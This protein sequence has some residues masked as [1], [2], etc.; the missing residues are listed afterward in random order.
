MS[1]LIHIIILPII[2]FM[3]IFC[4]NTIAFVDIIFLFFYALYLLY[5]LIK[6]FI[7]RG[8]NGRITFEE[9]TEEEKQKKHKNRKNNAPEE[10]GQ[11]AD[12]DA[13]IAEEDGKIVDEEKGVMEEE[14]RVKKMPESTDQERQ[15]KKTANENLQDRKDKLKERKGDH[16]ERK[17]RH[18]ERKA[19]HNAQKKLT[20]E[21]ERINNMDKNKPRAKARAQNALNKLQ[22]DLETKKMNQQIHNA[23]IDE[24]KEKQTKINKMTDGPKKTAAQSK[25]DKKI[26]KY[27]KKSGKPS[28]KKKIKTRVSKSKL[29]K[30]VSKGSKAVTKVTTTVDNI[31]D[32]A[33]SKLNRGRTSIKTNLGNTKVGKGV[34]K[35]GKGAGK[36]KK[37]VAKPLKPISK[38]DTK[39]KAMPETSKRWSNKIVEK[40]YGS[41]GKPKPKIKFKLSSKGLKKIKGVK[42]L[43]KGLA[44]AGKVMGKAGIVGAIITSGIEMRSDW[45]D[46]DKDTITKVGDVA[47]DAAKGAA[48]LYGGEVGAM[49]GEAV[50]N[51]LGASL[52]CLIPP[53]LGEALAPLLGAAMGHLLGFVGGVVGAELA[54]FVMDKGKKL[55]D[56]Y[57]SKKIHAIGD[58]IE[59]LYDSVHDEVN[60]IEDWTKHVAK[61]TWKEIK[62]I[63][64]KI[65]DL[66]NK[67]INFIGDVG[68]GIAKEATALGRDLTCS[69]RL[70]FK[71]CNFLPNCRH[72]KGHCISSL[73]CQCA[74]ETTCRLNPTCA[75]CHGKCMN[76]SF[77]NS[78]CSA[79]GLISE[80]GHLIDNLESEAADKIEHT[81]KEAKKYVSKKAKKVV[82]FIKCNSCKACHKACSNDHWV[83]LPPCSVCNN[84][85]RGC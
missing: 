31:A 29:G 55:W 68:D 16:E 6:V 40:R 63:N 21:Q 52:A 54:G 28:I 65:H 56:K 2:I 85:C 7:P 34:T 81:A 39:I 13:K 8:P 45:N 82:K 80:T 5:R 25:L 43:N 48:M 3:R 32:A 59:Y 36:V 67:A 20:T 78:F 10:D 19:N 14:G 71:A 37:F 49:V 51:V 41:S 1:I 61:D 70:S 53:P 27:D 26:N 46:P 4:N 64:R 58:G 42:M 33:Q 38:L 66:E 74:N 12:D 77:R 30:A 62:H 73:R 72:C 57:G 69:D 18:N 17:R 22:N 9:E 44:K 23:T 50:G 15:A 60:K 79:K 47:F 76:T 11:I 75:W 35:F 24:F 83:P 84:L